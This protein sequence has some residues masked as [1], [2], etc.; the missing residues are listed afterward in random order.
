LRREIVRMGSVADWASLAVTLLLGVAGLVLARN[1]RR[2]VE[3]KLADRRLAAYGRLWAEM[4][5]ASPYSPPMDPAGRAL[6]HEALTNWYYANGDG[7]L[8]P[9]VSRE[10]YFKAKDNLICAVEEV[11]PDAARDR[12]CRLDS[13]EL[14]RHRGLL[15]QRQMSLLRTQLKSDLAIY[16]RPYGPPLTDE[17]RDFL[18]ACGVDVKKKPWSASAQQHKRDR[19]DHA[20]PAGT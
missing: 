9:R 14:D 7:M 17:D 19:T 5:P 18:L 20:S 10:V 16:G 3:L 6:L 12:L 4:R 11:T 2:D 13:H 8:L 1:V 15:T